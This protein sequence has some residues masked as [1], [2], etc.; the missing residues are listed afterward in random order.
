VRLFPSRVNDGICDCCDGADEWGGA[1]IAA[2]GATVSCENTCGKAV[3]DARLSHEAFE[4]GATL[5][6]SYVSRASAHAADGV[7]GGPDNAYLALKGRCFEWATGDYVR[8]CLPLMSGPSFAF[9]LPP[10]LHAFF[11][12]CGA[13]F[14]TPS[15]VGLQRVS[16]EGGHAAGES[17]AWH[18]S[19]Q[20]CVARSRR[21]GAGRR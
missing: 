10:C 17:W 4:R 15:N 6:N 7:D 5:R 19:E 21:L 18:R 1:L 11:S 8:W 2:T 3:E 14:A 13:D 9:F 20:P 12:V 16:L